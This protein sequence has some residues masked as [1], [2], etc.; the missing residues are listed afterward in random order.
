M[1]AGVWA[2]RKRSADEG[3][4][5]V[6]LGGS[7][8]PLLLAHTGQIVTRVPGTGVVFAD[9]VSEAPPVFTHMLLNLQAVYETVILLTVR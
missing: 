7:L 4:N 5:E 2:S 1:S 8:Q 3:D 9:T 6:T